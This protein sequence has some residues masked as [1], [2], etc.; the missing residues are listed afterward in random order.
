M[1]LTF[2]TEPVPG[3]SAEQNEDCVVAGPSWVAVL[4]GA[5][6]PPGLPGGCRHGVAWVT[7]ALAA[8]LAARLAAE[9]GRRARRGESLPDLLAAAIHRV[10]TDH[11]GDCDLTDPDSPSA[12]V[13]IL[14]R[15]GCDLDWLVLC[16]SPLLLDLHGEVRVIR[17]DRVDHLADYTLEGV[18]KARNSS[19]GFWVASTRPEAAHQ[20]LTGT[21]RAAEV[22]C[23]GLFTDGA[24]RLVERF[25]R[26]DWAGLLGLLE[27]HGPA[28]LVKATREAEAA[29][30]VRG[31]PARRGKPY[32][33][34]TAVFVRPWFSHGSVCG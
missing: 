28:G 8:A 4:D 21:I 15:R 18:R 7:R 33:D 11:G 31:L 25:A 9:P 30:P 32:D 23:A 10:C 19:G 5:T 13:T 34:A 17:D 26:T 27:R 29:E 24:T 16:D 14:R 1:E 6:Q 22:R 20:A 12:T 3:R 2:A